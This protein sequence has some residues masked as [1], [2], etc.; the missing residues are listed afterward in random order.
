VTASLRLVE[1]SL[2]SC[3]FAIVER[4]PEDSPPSIEPDLPPDLDAGHIAPTEDAIDDEVPSAAVE[5]TLE[6]DGVSLFY[7][8]TEEDEQFA[9]ILQTSLTDAT[10]PYEMNIVTGSRY[11]L[12]DPPAT[13]AEAAATLVFIA[14]PYVREI[15]TN[16]TARSPYRA[17][18]LPPLTRLPHPRVSTEEPGAG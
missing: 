8:V 5:G 13:T 1:F 16:I 3:E 15:F 10:S 9:L 17:F 14:Y 4:V 7:S 11:T 12:P 2:L 18:M 6:L